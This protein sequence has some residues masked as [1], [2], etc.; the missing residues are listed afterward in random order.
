MSLVAGRGHSRRLAAF[1]PSSNQSLTPRGNNHP[2]SGSRGLSGSGGDRRSGWAHPV[3]R[4]TTY[5]EAQEERHEGYSLVCNRRGCDGDRLGRGG[6]R[7]GRRVVGRRRVP[8]RPAVG[9]H[10]HRRL[11]HGRSSSPEA[12]AEYFQEDNPDVRVTVGISGT[13]GGF[14][15]F[16][17]GETDANDASRQIEPDEEKALRGRRD[18][19][20]GDAGG[21]RR[22]RRRRQ[23]RE[24]RGPKA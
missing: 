3:R 9:G 21:Q 4:F 11:E 2:A 5:M 10:P 18:Q 1:T 22:H 20:G 17:A 16:A 13:G 23:S 14:E 6:L 8:D 15:K 24:Q 7:R 12:A 19:V